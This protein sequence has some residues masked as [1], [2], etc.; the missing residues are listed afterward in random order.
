MSRNIGDSERLQLRLRPGEKALIARAAALR[1][2]DLTSF[3]RDTALPE[4]RAVLR[5]AEQIHLSERDSLRIMKLLEDPPAPTE[6]LK[7]AA[8]MGHR[9]T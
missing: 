2:Q 4:A 5:E 9:L 1:R 6:R 3:I 8:K 7:R